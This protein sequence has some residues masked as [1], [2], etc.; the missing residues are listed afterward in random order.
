MANFWKRT[1]VLFAAG[2]LML[3]ASAQSVGAA[4]P[5]DKINHF[6]IIYQ[7]NQTFD[8]LYGKFPGANGLDS[9]GGKIAQVD[10]DG[11]AYATLPPV[12]N[13]WEKDAPVK[14]FP[15]NLP[16]A[17]FMIDQYVP[18]NQIIPSPIHRF[19]E[20]ILQ[21]NGGKMDKYVAWSD[22][23]A[24]A[25]G[26]NDTTKLPLYPYARGYALADNYFTA[27]FGGSMLNH[28]WLICACTPQW[29]DAPAKFI[30]HPQ[31]DASGKL[32]DPGETMS[33]GGGDGDVTP[34]GF[35][36]NDVDPRYNPHHA[37][38]PPEELAPP[39]DALTIG[40]RLSEKN[41]P[42][43]WYAQGWNDALAGKPDKLFIFEHQPF[44]YFRQ[45]GDGTAAKVEHLRDEN[46]F[47]A[48][49]ENG[50]LPAVSFIKPMG[51]VDEHSGYTSIAPSEQHA[52]DLIKAVQA[53]PY[54]KDSAII[55]TYDDFGGFYD[56]VAPPTV[57]RWG[58]G[59]RVPAIIISP[60]AKKGFVDHTL[61]DT[62]SLMKTI[63]ARWGLAPLATRDAAAA[64]LSN[65]FDF[66]QTPSTP[67]LPATGGNLDGDWN[68]WLLFAIGA[69]LVLCG[70]VLL[71]QR[72]VA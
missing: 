61:Y 50:T 18:N 7:E 67:T 2:V 33:N 46:D 31:Y 57:D 41:I 42:W 72:K 47:R 55:V 26:Y 49:L 13:S 10:K 64:D 4:G 32:T 22:D 36:V 60:Y 40:D 8:G 45:F 30:A 65:A 19:Y 52:V 56:H 39:Q 53:S 38:V 68:G 9:P 28:F 71:S 54:W 27:A 51:E 16:N 25:M 48:A 23:G 12:V 1:C 43:A 70:I 62:T 66:E 37:N 24:M 6:I 20:Y 3:V 63:E 59:G 29:A 15:P 58:P 17:P 69:M 35:L 44:V 21:I 34:D 11:K 14:S 5:F